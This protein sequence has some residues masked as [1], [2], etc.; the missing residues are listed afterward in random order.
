ME[1]G[2]VPKSIQCCMNERG[3]SEA[4]AREVIKEL[5]MDNWRVING[6]RACSSS[7]EEYF[8]SVAINVPR[9]SLFFYHH[10]DGY[11]KSDEETRDHI[12]S[13]LLQPFKI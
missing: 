2:D 1:R 4:A 11:S 12:I 10:G 9:T 5:I 3:V 6:D 13:L 7:F 8:K